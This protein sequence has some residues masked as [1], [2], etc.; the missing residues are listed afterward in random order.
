[1]D[2]RKIRFQGCLAMG[3]WFRRHYYHNPNRLLPVN[4]ALGKLVWADTDHCS[5]LSMVVVTYVY[6]VAHHTHLLKL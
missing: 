5:F 1:M 4:K 6:R 2:T 3:D